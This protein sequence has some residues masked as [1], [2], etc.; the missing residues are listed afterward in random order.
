[1]TFF[2]PIYLLPHARALNIPYEMLCQFHPSSAAA[3]PSPTSTVRATPVS[4]GPHM[5]PAREPLS[6]LRL[7]QDGTRRCGRCWGTPNV[8]LPTQESIPWGWVK[9]R[10]EYQESCVGLSRANIMGCNFMVC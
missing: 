6:E 1:M 4:N 3:S 7:L 5:E 10:R 8:G 9:L 2:F